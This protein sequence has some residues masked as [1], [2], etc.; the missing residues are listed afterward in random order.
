LQEH[1]DHAISLA[2]NKRASLA[3]APIVFV[4]FCA[5]VAMLVGDRSMS[6][7]MGIV[8]I[9][10]LVLFYPWHIFATRYAE[11]SSA[12]PPAIM[13]WPPVIFLLITGYVLI[14]RGN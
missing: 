13:Y 11:A 2:I 8:V 10:V 5:P 14:N 12:I 9:P 7:G 4:V 1:S 3:L 6:G